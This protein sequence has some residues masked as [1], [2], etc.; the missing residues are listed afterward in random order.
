MD[1]L[2]FG[3][4]VNYPEIIQLL[5]KQTKSLYILQLLFSITPNC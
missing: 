5:M 2:Q 3:H 4:F 1:V